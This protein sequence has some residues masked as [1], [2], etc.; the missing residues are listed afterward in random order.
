[1]TGDEPADMETRRTESGEPPMSPR[2][3]LDDAAIPVTAFVQ[4]DSACDR[5]EEDCRAGRDPD[6]AA[7]LAAAP[8]GARI[9]LFRN[10]LNLDLEYRF[11]RGERP[12]AGWYRERFPELADV[13]DSVFRSLTERP[14]TIDVQG[15]APDGESNEPA[16]PDGET[17]PADREGDA[18]GRAHHPRIGLSR[19]ESDDLRSAGYEVRRLLGRGGMGVVYEAHQV[20]LNRPVAIKLVRS[21]SFAS[22]SELLRF[23]NEAEAVAQLDHPHVVP[24][25]EV[26]THRDRHF[27]S[28][29][30]IAGSSLDRRLAEFADD[31]RAAARLVAV[32]AEAIHHAHQRGILHRDLKPANILIDEKGQPHVTDF[33]LAKRIDGDPELTHRTP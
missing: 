10:M 20:S 14:E 7:H 16:D 24:I 17:R 30:L 31:P 25:Y 26:G 32:V 1:M 6:M 19:A 21:G 9:P 27:F 12:D 33:G 29:K 4:I 18:D 2:S 13:V 11:R 15:S 8:E 5:F 3:T 22:E 28:M 23:R